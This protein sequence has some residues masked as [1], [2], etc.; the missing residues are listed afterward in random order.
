M[1]PSAA[2][3]SRP[4][5]RTGLKV[6]EI[7]FGAWGI[8]RAMWGR[9]DDAES[10][11][12]LRKAL[13]L[14]VN[15]FDT[16]YVYGHGHSERLIS[17]ALREAGLAGAAEP[18]GRILLATKIPPKNMEWPAHPHGRL[19]GAFPPEWIEA[20]TERSLRNLRADCLSLQQLHVW[21]DAWLKDPFWPQSLGA[22]ER[23]KAQGKIRYLGI[24]VNSGE[25]GSAFAAALSGVFDTVQVVLNLFEQGAAE[26]LLPLCA[27]RGVGVIV[28]CPF[29][30]GGLSGLT[31]QTRFEPEDFRSYYFGGERLAETCRRAEALKASLAS[32]WAALPEAAIKFCLSF[33]EVSCVI[34]GMRQSAHVEANVRAADGRYFDKELLSEL[35]KHAWARDFYH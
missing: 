32:R 16:A 8:S 19:E 14:G 10:L 33:P 20:C 25:P 29:D 31:P 34:P 27:E 35:R 21:T 22:L 7:G 2:L 4:L 1:N 5:G 30:E 28:R 3:A 23:L 17:Q 26:R 12:A 11:R 9:T 13:D 18:Q 24:S 6:S 15:F